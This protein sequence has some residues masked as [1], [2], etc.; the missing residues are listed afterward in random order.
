MSPLTRLLYQTPGKI[1]CIG[2][3]YAAHIS[4]LGHETP[5]QP[6]FFL[7][8]ASSILFPEE[9]NVKI[10]KGV[11]VHHEVELAVII[12][13]EMKNLNPE[14]F[15]LKEAIEYIDGYALS[16]D[17]TAR[18][19]QNEASRKGLPWS[20][21]KG[22]DTFLPLSPII[23]KDIITD[24]S[25]VTLKLS[26]NGESKQ[27]DSTSLML[28]PLQKILSYTSTIMTLQKGDIILTGTPKGV[29]PLIPGD[30][31]SCAIDVDGIQ[32]EKLDFD[33]EAKEPPYVYKET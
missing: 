16:V 32:V 30:H 5:A 9:G 17:L 31:V 12:G 19:V 28:F 22:F 4:E 29:G 2:R 18:N 23:S 26:V 13:K 3:N 20:I 21:S 25:N 7:K 33:C 6:F 24:P 15:T 14:T 8:P 10:P 27:D 11:V 1:L